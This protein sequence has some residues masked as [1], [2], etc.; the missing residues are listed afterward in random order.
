MTSLF[1][2]LCLL[3]TGVF[4]PDSKKAIIGCTRMLKLCSHK[5]SEITYSRWALQL[6]K[7]KQYKKAKQKFKR[8]IQI[9]P[10]AS[11]LY[12]A[13]LKELYFTREFEEVILLAARYI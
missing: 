8:S 6:L 3:E 10:D 13:W 1:I 11:Y 4:S 9:S 7:Q 2:D 5:Y 12:T